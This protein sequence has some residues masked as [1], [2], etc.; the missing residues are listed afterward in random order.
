MAREDRPA[1]QAVGHDRDVPR[2]PGS[3]AQHPLPGIV[4]AGVERG[5]GLSAGWLVVGAEDVRCEAAVWRPAHVAEVALGERRIDL[6]GRAGR[7]AQRLGRLDGAGEVAGDDARDARVREPRRQPGGLLP[8]PL[9]EW[10]FGQMEE[11][12]RITVGLGVTQEVDGH[13]VPEIH[14]AA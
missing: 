13:A 6:D 4:D 3:E 14:L 2:G 9:A 1:D 8:P 11:A 5:P 12:G 7:R 10:Y